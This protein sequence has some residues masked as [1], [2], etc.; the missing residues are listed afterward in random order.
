MHIYV[1]VSLLLCIHSIIA[2]Y[3]FQHIFT[4][5]RNSK[6]DVY[7]PQNFR[8]TTNQTWISRKHIQIPYGSQ[9]RSMT[10]FQFSMH[11]RMIMYKGCLIFSFH[12]VIYISIQEKKYWR[13]KEKY[14]CRNRKS[15]ITRAQFALK[16]CVLRMISATC[17]TGINLKLSTSPSDILLN[18][19]SQRVR[20]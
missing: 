4:K 1:Q 3:D 8:M 14:P 15:M 10:T 6:S 16:N 12:L 19:L 20:T 17:V 2:T 5:P 9:N 13:Y 7:S 18:Q 11:V